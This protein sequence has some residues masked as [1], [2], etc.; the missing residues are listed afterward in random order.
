MNRKILFI[1]ILASLLMAGCH[2]GSD[3]P[4]I[5][6][7]PP[8][9]G[10]DP[11]PDPKPE[12]DPEPSLVP[13]ELYTALLSRNIID[14]FN[15][16]AIGIV[17]E[18]SN[19]K[20]TEIWNG[21]AGPE[22]ITLDSIRYYPTDSSTV[23]IRG[24]YPRAYYD[25]G[26]VS[27]ALTGKEDL[28]YAGEQNGSL[29]LPF[30]ATRSPL[31]FHHL[32]A[33]L[34]ID[35]QTSQDFAPNYRLKAFHVYGSSGKATLDISTGKM[36]FDG[37]PV[38]F[39]SYSDSE[40]KELL[41]DTRFSLESL[42]IEPGASLTAE[43]VLIHDTA[44]GEKEIY[45]KNLPI[46]FEGGESTSGT[47]YKIEIT[48]PDNPNPT[49][50]PDPDPDPGPDPDPDPKPEPDPEPEPE[51]KPEPEPEPDIPGTIHLWAAVTPWIE[52]DNGNGGE[53]R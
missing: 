44:E 21:T 1:W 49:P 24:Y 11:E 35:M 31:T 26:I 5:P 48:L 30:S 2:H 17:A 47:S 50:D 40:G 22:K 43:I 28:L 27:Y 14:S 53:L 42:L 13:I 29:I 25:A 8:A 12:P 3:D 23:Y 36:N 4:I 18:Y 6:P 46:E 15:Q 16:T 52:G 7:D 32:M 20:T 37:I 10:P 41:P 39:S 51:P 34:N 45:L 9:P 19:E 33:Q 38:R